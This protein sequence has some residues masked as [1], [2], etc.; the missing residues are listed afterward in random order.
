MQDKL[1]MSP[2][3]KYKAKW[4]DHNQA[5][6]LLIAKEQSA[7]KQLFDDKEI[8]EELKEQKSPAKRK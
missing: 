6:F 4:G 3:D 8:K 7:K 2:E 1:D 5:H